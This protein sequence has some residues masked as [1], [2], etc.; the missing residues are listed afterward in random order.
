MN[1]AERISVQT[2]LLKMHMIE[3]Y[4]SRIKKLQAVLISIFDDFGLVRHMTAF[5]H[6]VE[7]GSVLW[8]SS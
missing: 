4:T 6:A 1:S 5:V 8:G 2:V 3:I 7:G